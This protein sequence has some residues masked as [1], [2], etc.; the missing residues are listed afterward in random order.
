[1]AHKPRPVLVCGLGRFGG[2]LARELEAQGHEV[3]GV[4]VDD[5]FV[6]DVAAEITSAARADTTD[7]EALR[8]LGA[9]DFGTAVV[10]IGAV[11]PSVLTVLAL[12]DLGVQEVWAKAVSAQHAVILERVGVRRVV[13]PE[14]DSGRRLAHLVGHRAQD[15][16]PLGD[17]FAIVTT[18]P[19][20]EL[21][22]RTLADAHV[23]SR[24]G[25]T[26][27]ALRRGDEWTY[28]QADTVVTEG[29]LLVAAGSPRHVQRF[30]DHR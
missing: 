14:A 20:R 15:Y 23:R 11:E 30:S 19:A 4:D 3:L 5:R 8:Q 6:T 29:D 21:L 12:L 22:G 25:V 16:L 24:W 28:A 17:D 2:A 1:M 26:V 7:L 27:V 9:G 10:S 13:Q 18:T